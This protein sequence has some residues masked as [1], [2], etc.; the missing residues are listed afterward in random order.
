MDG[1]RQVTVYTNIQNITSDDNINIIQVKPPEELQPNHHRFYWRC[2]ILNFLWFTTYK[3]V[4]ALSLDADM[5]A[6]SNKVTRYCRYYN[7]EFGICFP[8]NRRFITNI[9]LEKVVIQVK[10]IDIFFLCSARYS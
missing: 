2:K 6:V 7:I 10:F 5:A 8:N 1:W 3:N 9:D 4:K